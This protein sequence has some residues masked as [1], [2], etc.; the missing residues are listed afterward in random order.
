MILTKPYSALMSAVVT[1]SGYESKHNPRL[2][3]NDLSQM[4]DLALSQL[5][6]LR[7]RGAFSTVAQAFA[8]CCSR[9][10]KVDQ[11]LMTTLPQ[12]WYKVR[13]NLEPSSKN[14]PSA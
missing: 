7:H 10:A 1:N 6:E 14:G 9:C 2:S 5:A 3:Q 8:A 4:G 12:K 13:Q 11:P